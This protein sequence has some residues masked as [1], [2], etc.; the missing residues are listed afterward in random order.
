VV[1]NARKRMARRVDALGERLRREMEE[2][3]E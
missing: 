1:R 2:S 3:I